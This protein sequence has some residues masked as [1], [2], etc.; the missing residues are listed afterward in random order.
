MPG[1]PTI[2]SRKILRTYLWQ[3]YPIK[4]SVCWYSPAL[5]I[6]TNMQIS[7]MKTRG[8]QRTNYPTENL[9]MLLLLPHTLEA[10]YTNSKRKNWIVIT[11]YSKMIKQ[12]PACHI[13]TLPKKFENKVWIQAISSTYCVLSA[14]QRI[15]QTLLPWKNNL[16]I[17]EMVIEGPA[18]SS[19]K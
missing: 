10:T 8:E 2:S 6:T 1:G 17:S 19:G 4:G 15:P 5:C 11:F 16:S 9:S 14:S 13:T 3:Q 7:I 12:H 18:T